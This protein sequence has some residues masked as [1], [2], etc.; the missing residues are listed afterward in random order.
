MLVMNTDLCRWFADAYASG[1]D[2]TDPDVSPMYADLSGLP[3]AL[4]IVGTQDPL[5]DDTLLLASRWVA[6]GNP[7]ELM[8]VTGAAHGFAGAPTGVGSEA[9][10]RID[11]FVAERIT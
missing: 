2:V 9:R 8:V 10:E 7:A 3:P 6:A 11:R 4:F 5:L 1:A